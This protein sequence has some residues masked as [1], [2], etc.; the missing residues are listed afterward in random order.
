[1][2]APGRSIGRDASATGARARFGRWRSAGATLE[3]YEIITYYLSTHVQPHGRRQHVDDVR[4]YLE[5][6]D[7]VASARG[8][9]DFANISGAMQTRS[10]RFAAETRRLPGVVQKICTKSVW[11]EPCR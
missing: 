9:S 4:E 11:S 7:L 2:S 1:V 5:I 10:L 8:K 6:L 3:E